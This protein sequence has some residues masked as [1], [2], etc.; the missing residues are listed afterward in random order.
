MFLMQS[1]SNNKINISNT[2]KNQNLNFN[3]NGKFQVNGKIGNKK[4]SNTIESGTIVNQYMKN[5]SNCFNNIINNEQVYLFNKNTIMNSNANYLSN[6]YN[7][8]NSIFVNVMN[9]DNNKFTFCNYNTNLST[10]YN[11]NQ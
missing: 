9:K 6:N 4:I 3:N 8:H 5:K 7:N 2:L 10:D 1:I 11:N